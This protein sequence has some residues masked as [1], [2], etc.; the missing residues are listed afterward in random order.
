M[1][2][3]CDHPRH[4]DVVCHETP[5]PQPV[6][7]PPGALVLLAAVLLLMLWRWGRA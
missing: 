3:S 4:H 6:P 1:S 7:E 2:L 5:P